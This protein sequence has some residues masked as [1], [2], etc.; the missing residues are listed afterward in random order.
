M[1]EED[2]RESLGDKR[3]Q[4]P[5]EPVNDIKNTPEA[6]TNENETHSQSSTLQREKVPGVGVFVT[7]Y[8]STNNQT[9]TK[10]CTGTLINGNQVIT[11][12]HCT[13]KTEKGPEEFCSKMSFIHA[14]E[15]RTFKCSKV[16]WSS[17]SVLKETNN[18]PKHVLSDV[19]IIQL[20]AVPQ[21]IKSYSLSPKPVDER[22]SHKILA[23]SPNKMDFPDFKSGTDL[24]SVAANGFDY[25]FTSYA[26]CKISDS[27]AP[28]YPF[29]SFD[30]PV[31]G[32][33]SGSPVFNNS[34]QLQGII[35]GCIE[36]V[37]N[38][39][40]KGNK[41]GYMTDVSCIE[42]VNG[43]YQWKSSCALS[44]PISST[45]PLITRANQT[46]N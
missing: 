17:S 39:C 18:N 16:L 25:Y 40:L 31:I 9:K 10:N 20:D 22:T 7:I 26:N 35:G 34:K 14:N 36:A 30:C 43:N 2:F 8:D 4:S 32:G 27:Y 11:A 5:V 29:R 21:N 24:K 6:P 12:D 42:N 3:L 38:D 1:N 44:G 13:P 15:N 46:K 33:N 45:A 41:G 19:L 28:G 23:Y 37:D